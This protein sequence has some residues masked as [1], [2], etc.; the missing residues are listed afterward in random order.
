MYT[1]KLRN[2]PAKTSRIE[3]CFIKTV[4]IEIKSVR[5]RVKNFTIEL[6]LKHTEFLMPKYKVTLIATCKLGNTLED[7]SPICNNLTS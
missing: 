2:I 4:D 1:I 5:I 6:S 3:C 7:E